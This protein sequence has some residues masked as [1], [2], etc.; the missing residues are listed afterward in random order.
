MEYNCFML[1]KFNYIKR[2][3][4]A[5]TIDQVSVLCCDFWSELT[6]YHSASQNNQKQ[7]LFEVLLERGWRKLSQ[8]DRKLEWATE[9]PVIFDLVFD[10][11]MVTERES[12]QSLC[13]TSVAGSSTL[14]HIL[15]HNGL[16]PFQWILR[17]FKVS[18]GKEN[19]LLITN[20]NVDNM[21]RNCNI[22]LITKSEYL[23]CFIKL[24]HKQQTWK[25]DQANETF[26]LTYQF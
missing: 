13:R 24:N 12:R 11:K 7:A 18:E 23:L 3:F 8:W 1:N 19:R 10:R 9:T 26:I 20:L 14:L 5:T 21:Y 25:R 4:R 17:C 2:G 6:E 22:S 15:C 16:F